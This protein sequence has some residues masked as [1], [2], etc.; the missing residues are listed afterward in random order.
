MRIVRSKGCSGEEGENGV[1]VGKMAVNCVS[2]GGSWKNRTIKA[3]V[4]NC[5]KKEMQWEARVAEGNLWEGR[6]GSGK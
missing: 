3:A 4:D 1:A 5:E 2:K 6:G